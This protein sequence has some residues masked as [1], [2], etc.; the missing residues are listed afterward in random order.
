MRYWN[1]HHIT[2]QRY[3]SC[4]QKACTPGHRLAREQRGKLIELVEELTDPAVSMAEACLAL[5]LRR[6]TLYRSTSLKAPPTWREQAPSLRRLSREER[7]AIL[8]VMPSEEFKEQPRA[9]H[10]Q[11]S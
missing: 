8:D 11:H 5:G 2:P 6:A 4:S 7:E 10:L 9:R 3:W 1:A